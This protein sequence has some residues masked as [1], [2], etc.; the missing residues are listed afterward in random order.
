M[1]FYSELV[2]QTVV[3]QIRKYYL[4]LKIN[5]LSSHEKTEETQVQITK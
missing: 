4:A 3:F 5:E 2:K 1:P